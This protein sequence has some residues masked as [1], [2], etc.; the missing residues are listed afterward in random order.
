MKLPTTRFLVAASAESPAMLMPSLPFEEI[1][2]RSVEASPPIVLA[3]EEMLIPERVLR[4]GRLPVTSVPMKLLTT[5]LPSA[6]EPLMTSPLPRNPSITRPRT[7]VFP[8]RIVSPSPLY[9]G[10]GTSSTTGWAV[11]APACDC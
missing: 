1:R 11:L 7:V 4:R 3:D 10:P 2:F 8:D 5:R 6:L 9:S